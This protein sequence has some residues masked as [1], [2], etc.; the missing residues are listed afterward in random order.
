MQPRLITRNAVEI[1]AVFKPHRRWP[2]ARG[3]G[4]VLQ[5][6]GE[7]D[8]GDYIEIVRQICLDPLIVKREYV[9]LLYQSDWLGGWGVFFDGEGA[10]LIDGPRLDPLGGGEFAQSWRDRPLADLIAAF[11]KLRR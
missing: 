1:L 11:K 2:G 10:L 8:R 4:E 9:L 5:A 7:I 6:G 3:R